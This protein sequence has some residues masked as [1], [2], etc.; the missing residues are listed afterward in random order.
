[1]K[2]NRVRLLDAV[3]AAIE[4]EQQRH[5][6]DAD[7]KLAAYNEAVDTWRNSDHPKLLAAQLRELANKAI[8]GIVV[9]SGD[10]DALHYRDDTHGFKGGKRPEVKPYM[11]EKRLTLL[12]DILLATEDEMVTTSALAELG[13]RNISDLIR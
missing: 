10:L 11:V 4:S 7:G 8:R 6:A 9:T 5:Q 13:F 1:M 12:R 3:D 2:I